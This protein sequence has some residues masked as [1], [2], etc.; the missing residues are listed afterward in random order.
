LR[1]CKRP[2]GAARAHEFVVN[3]AQV[4]V[5]AWFRTAL[6]SHAPRLFLVLCRAATTAEL[7]LVGEDLVARALHRG[8]ARIEARRLRTPWG[9]LDLLAHDER[10]LVAIEVKSARIA[11]RPRIR[12]QAAIPLGERDRPGAR[13]DARG[14]ERLGRIALGISARRGIPARAEVFEVLVGPGRFQLEIQRKSGD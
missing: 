3:F 9:E 11:P 6:R 12:G 4:L 1:A 8:G 5:R 2:F 7:G 10:G 13:V 14:R